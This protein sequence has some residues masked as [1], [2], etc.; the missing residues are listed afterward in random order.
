MNV[1]QA[2]EIVYGNKPTC[3]RELAE[4]REILRAAH[5]ER[6]VDRVFRVIGG[7]MTHTRAVPYVAESDHVNVDELRAAYEAAF[8]QAAES[9]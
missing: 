5:L 1:T 2:R 8:E 4:A 6:A 9:D 7:G 3:E